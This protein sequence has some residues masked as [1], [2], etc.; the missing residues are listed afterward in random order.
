MIAVDAL[1]QTQPADVR[2]ACLIEMGHIAVAESYEAVQFLLLT[3][4]IEPC[5]PTTAEEAAKRPRRLRAR[6]IAP[7]AVTPR[8]RLGWYSAGG[9]REPSDGGGPT[10]YGSAI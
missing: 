4:L 8:T 7:A 10:R 6:L 1:T 2:L 5:R 9:E 3:R